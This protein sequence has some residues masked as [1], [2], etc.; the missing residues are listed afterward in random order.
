MCTCALTFAFWGEVI[1]SAEDLKQRKGH[2]WE[3]DEDLSILYLLPKVEKK[4]R[5]SVLLLLLTYFCHSFSSI[6]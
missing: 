2:M 5:V 6:L 1:A 4:L 3:F